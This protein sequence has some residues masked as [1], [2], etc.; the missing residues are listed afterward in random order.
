[1]NEEDDKKLNKDQMLMVALIKISV[2]EKLL[3]ES[4]IISEEAYSKAINEFS[5]KFKLILESSIREK[6]SS[7]Q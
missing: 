7:K 4:N 3:I 1:M 2:L 5:E 6:V